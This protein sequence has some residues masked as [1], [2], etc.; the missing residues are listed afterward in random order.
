MREDPR[1]GVVPLKSYPGR[2]AVQQDGLYLS[3]EG[4]D[5]YRV[6]WSAVRSAVARAPGEIDVEI[7]KVGDVPVPGSLGKSIW[8]HMSADKKNIGDLVERARV[9]RV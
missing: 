3:F 2:A 6:P 1:D 7:S 8:S 9:D 4:D 5:F